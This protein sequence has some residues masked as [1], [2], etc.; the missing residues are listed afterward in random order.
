MLTL[1]RAQIDIGDRHRIIDG[2]QHLHRVVRTSLRVGNTRSWSVA[3]AAGVIK[4]LVPI[5][6]GGDVDRHYL[7]H[8]L[9]V[10]L[11][12]DVDLVVLVVAVAVVALDHLAGHPELGEAD[13]LNRLAADGVVLPGL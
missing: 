9:H 11:E 2:L 6:R 5:L 13:N 10:A 8:D 1:L 4:R 12:D 3:R 7:A